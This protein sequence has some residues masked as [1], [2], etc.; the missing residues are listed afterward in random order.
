[1]EDDWIDDKENDWVG[2]FDPD[3][4]LN[5]KDE[6]ISIIVVENGNNKSYFTAGEDNWDW[7]MGRNL[8]DICLEAGFVY[9]RIVQ[10]LI[11][12]GFIPEHEFNEEV[13][14][15]YTANCLQKKVT[16]IDTENNIELDPCQRMTFEEIENS[17]IGP[18][19]AQVIE[20]SCFEDNS[21]LSD[22]EWA[23]YMRQR[24][25]SKE[26]KPVY[27]IDL[28]NPKP[29]TELQKE[30][31]RKLYTALGEFIDKQP[32]EDH[33]PPQVCIS[34]DWKISVDFG[35]WIKDTDIV[36]SALCLMCR[37]DETGRFYLDENY[38]MQC[39]PYFEDELEDMSDDYLYRNG[40]IVDK[41]RTRQEIRWDMEWEFSHIV[42][43]FID[44]K[45][46]EDTLIAIN[47]DNLTVY[48]IPGNMEIHEVDI[49]IYKPQDFI[50]KKLGRKPSFDDHKIN[51]LIKG[52]IH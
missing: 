11:V 25:E 38:V 42:S 8:I 7:L 22:E 35:G 23:E 16:C 32:K 48:S 39:V 36:R 14:F 13:R 24:E 51:K 44:K 6:G 10:L 29:L 18:S 19:M 28:N 27:P 50:L 30:R 52:L 5:N 12:D 34:Q 15:V 49:N 40:K 31:G 20:S 21:K 9:N 46:S 43:D 47:T 45:C 37:D 2:D 1:M 26:W 3:S 17:G 33:Y 4:F 41:E